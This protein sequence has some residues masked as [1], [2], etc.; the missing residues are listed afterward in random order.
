MNTFSY[1][2]YDAVKLEMQNKLR[3]YHHQVD[4][5]IP[6]SRQDA[7]NGANLRRFLSRLFG[8][9]PTSQP[10]RRHS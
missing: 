6:M 7:G 3:Y 8:K 1:D 5:S 9:S 4:D 10:E 2:H